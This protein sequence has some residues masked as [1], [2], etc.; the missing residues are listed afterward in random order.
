MAVGFWEVFIIFFKDLFFKMYVLISAMPGLS[1]STWD[2]RSSLRHVGSLVAAC[3]LLI[4]AG[5]I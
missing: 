5:G 4:V 1:C 3:K 2:L